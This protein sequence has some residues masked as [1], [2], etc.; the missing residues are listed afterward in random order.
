MVILI[1][2]LILLRL[3][4]ISYPKDIEEKTDIVY[5]ESFHDYGSIFKIKLKSGKFFLTPLVKRVEVRGKEIA[6]D[7]DIHNGDIIAVGDSRFQFK[8]YPGEYLYKEIFCRPVR[9]LFP[10]P[11]SVQYISGW[12]EADRRKVLANAGNRE[13]LKRTMVELAPEELQK[14]MPGLESSV[15]G[16]AVLELRWDSKTLQVRPLVSDV[17]RIRELDEKIVEKDSVISA[18]AGDILR[19]HPS[20]YIKFDYRR[21]E[22]LQNLVISYR[23]EQD[24][25]FPPEPE[26]AILK[27]LDT[28]IA[29]DI[30]LSRE[31]HFMGKQG[32]FSFNLD[33]GELMDKLYI[34]EKVPQGRV[35]DLKELLDRKMYYRKDGR[36]LAVTIEFLEDVR[37][38]FK[39]GPEE[40]KQFFEKSN[41]KWRSFKDYPAFESY[42]N[43]AEP[44]IG[45]MENKGIYKT[46]IAEIGQL[47][48]KPGQGK[49][50]SIGKVFQVKNNKI[51]L[52]QKQAHRPSF[53]KA[54][55]PQ[56]PA[57]VDAENNI[58]AYSS[59]INGANRRFYATE[60]PPDMLGLLGGKGEETWAL[61]QIFSG[62]YRENRIHDIRLT[63]NLEW[64]KIALKAMRKMLLENRETEINNPKYQA[65]RSEFEEVKAQSAQ[66]GEKGVSPLRKRLRELKKEIDLEKNRFYEASVVLLDPE[67]RI[68]VAASYP[69]DEATLLE[70]NPEL[71]GPYRRDT[72]PHLNRAWKWKYNPGSTAKILDSIAFLCSRERFPYLQRLLTSGSAFAS[73]PR[74]DLKGSTMLN[75]KEIPFRLRNFQGHDIPAGFCSLVEAFTHSY[76]TY[77]AYLA[78]H[79]SN[80]LMVDSQ[81]YTHSRSFIK[82]STVPVSG[83]YREYPVLEYAE[84]L[85]MNRKLNLLSNLSGTPIHDGL[86]RM[87]Y[88]AFVA[89]E[90]VFPVNAYTAADIAHYAIGQGDFQL[91][92]LQ[93]ALTASSILNNGALY[94]PSIIESV[95]LRETDNRP[96]QAIIPDPEKS[97]IRVFPAYV[98]GEIKDAMQAVALRGTAGG[99]FGELM[100]GRIFYA[101][102]G[103]AETGF[104]KDNALFNGFVKFRNNEYVVF[105]VIVPRSGLGARIAGKLTTQ[106]MG[107][108]I[109]YENKRGN[110]L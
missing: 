83:V 26:A 9:S 66:P 14:L 6:G 60:V 57:I 25:P 5:L 78:L 71:P 105:S 79:D 56:K 89:I 34:P 17:A 42:V 45:K 109:E 33:P 13:L 94:F 88:D 80:V 47:D 22:G 36:F 46:F 93:N 38:Y 21:V 107:D 49:K 90:S 84:R 98:A 11:A 75:G 61:E 73:F 58:L 37:K 10:G 16:G 72:N 76:N 55:S 91:T 20:L 3:Y 15:F 108:I 82:K 95:R 68:L 110:L 30:N 106:I 67:G 65:L 50:E 87:P 35:V 12:P 62:L 92:A 100:K 43:K 48:N 40:L 39:Q 77:F 31:T 29:Y 27:S 23:Q 32:L 69:Y 97:K 103:T 4:S 54:K 2:L 99:V 8:V 96:G 102:T 53:R 7:I 51:Y 44:L 101:K 18:A 70:L 1:G 28:G 81:V 74:T 86:Q 52:I 64:Q 104:S 41:I 19:I 63:F 24:Y 59:E 85:L